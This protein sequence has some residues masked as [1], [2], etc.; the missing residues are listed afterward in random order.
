MDRPADGSGWYEG[1]GADPAWT[2]PESIRLDYLAP[3]ADLQPYITTFYLFRCDEPLIRDVQPAAV[4]QLQIYLRGSGRML[5]PHGRTDRSFPETI[6]GPTTIAAPF[7]VDGLPFL[8]VH[9]V[10]HMS[11]KGSDLE[12]NVVALCPNCHQRC[13]HSDDREAFTAWLYDN[14]GRLEKE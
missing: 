3:P 6:Q 14:V 4:G 13:H 12:T 2:A 8:E 9:H 11:Q 1:D 10:K 5:Y 7:E